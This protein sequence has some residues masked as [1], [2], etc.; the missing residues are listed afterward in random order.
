MDLSAGWAD[1]A[2]TCL[3]VCACVCVRACLGRIPMGPVREQWSAAQHGLPLASAGGRKPNGF[4]CAGSRDVNPFPGASLK[5]GEGN[6]VRVWDQ[7]A[8]KEP[9]AL[10]LAL[11]FSVAPCCC[12]S[13]RSCPVAPWSPAPTLAC[14]PCP[15]H[16]TG[17]TFLLKELA[18]IMPSLHSLPKLYLSCQGQTGQTMQGHHYPNNK[19]SG[20]RGS[21]VG[22]E[23]QE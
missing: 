18:G 21:L 22:R 7:A 9:P 15:K 16:I 3:C 12:P 19:A 4:A 23:R 14:S 17:S 8:D 20:T 11:P 6:E 13:D 1:G 10:F 5:A 2:Q